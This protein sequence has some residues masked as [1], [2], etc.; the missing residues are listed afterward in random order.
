M[1]ILVPKGSQGFYAEPFSHYTDSLR[2]T[3]G[4]GKNKPVIWDGTSVEAMRDEREWIGQRGSKF[5]V[6]AKSG[7]KIYLELIGQLQ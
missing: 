7:N 2:F 4:E 1:I 5:K 6:V 3:W